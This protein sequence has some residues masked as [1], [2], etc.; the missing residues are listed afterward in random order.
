MNRRD[1]WI[2]MIKTHIHS[3]CVSDCCVLAQFTAK[4]TVEDA[5]FLAESDGSC[6]SQ[7][8][9][10]LDEPRKQQKIEAK[11][12]LCHRTEY[13]LINESFHCPVGEKPIAD[14]WEN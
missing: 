12:N 6:A 9:E 8:E 4:M 5:C 3:G 1:G 2:R 7:P 11:A 14:V 10:H 13:F